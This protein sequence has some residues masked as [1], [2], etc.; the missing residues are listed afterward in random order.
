MK[1]T[2]RTDCNV[3]ADALFAAMADVGYFEQ[4][5]V[6]YG[7]RLDRLDSGPVLRE[8]AAWRARFTYRNRER[9]LTSQLDR[10]EAPKLLRFSGQSG[11]F[12]FVLEATLA[13]LSRQTTRVGA[14]LELKPATIGARILL[15]TLKLGRT[16][17]EARMTQ[18]LISFVELLRQRVRGLQH[19]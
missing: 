4:L 18:R 5:A 17:L 2:S 9:L 3:P 10:I 11:S 6:R 12:S 15:Q 14:A 13:P 19:H 8:G 7:V 1:L 16:R